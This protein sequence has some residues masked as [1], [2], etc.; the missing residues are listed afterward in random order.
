M[1]PATKDTLAQLDNL[2]AASN[3]SWLFGA[4]ISLDA[5]IPLMGPLTDR[6]LTLAET[7]EEPNDIK[8]LQFVKSQ[9]SDNSHIEHILSQLGDHRAI[10]DRSK[11]KTVVFDSVTLSVDELDKLHQKILTW[12]AETIRWGYKPANPSVGQEV[13]GTHAN[14]I[15]VIDHHSAFVSALFNRSQAGVAER[16][17]AVRLFTTNYD[18]L[19][20]D[21]LALGGFS[22]W[23]G[24]SG[25]AVAYRSHRY[26]DE[27]PSLGDRAHIIKLHGSIDWHLGED[28][29]VW[30]VRDGDLY[31]KRASRVLIYPQSTKYL[32]TQRD[33]FAAQFDLFRRALSAREENVLATCGYSFGDEHINQEIELALQRPENKTTVLAFAPSLNSTLERWRTGPWGKRVYVITGDGLYVGADGPHSSPTAQAKRDWWTFAGVTKM[34]NS[35]AGASV[36]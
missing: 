19:L 34:L 2:L 36:L 33:P 10:A 26:G 35:G 12:I 14:R 28:D 15:V 18:T 8:V 20:E 16:R 17:R 7:E 31:P 1:N 27:E 3:Q 4:G 29:R 13:I 25:G 9:L 21:A 32:A 11:D 22:Y 24:F 30:R 5:G 23:D 6:V